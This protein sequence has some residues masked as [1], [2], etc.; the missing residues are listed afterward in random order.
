VTVTVTVQLLDA[1]MV[2]PLK[3]SEVPPADA[4]AVPPGHVV[5]A[6]GVEAFLRLAG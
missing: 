5:E 4:V 1:G 6:A 2:A 3:D